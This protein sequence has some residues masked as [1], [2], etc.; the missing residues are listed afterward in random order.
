L[1]SAEQLENLEKIMKLN[2]LRCLIVGMVLLLSACNGDPEL[3]WK[4]IN[5]GALVVDVR[6]PD[7]YKAGH[8]AG[9]LLLPDYEIE[10]H[11]DKLGEKS[12][13]IVLYSNRG[14]RAQLAQEILQ[15]LGYTDVTNGGAY[16]VL[17]GIKN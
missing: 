9:A 6:T 1:C 4:K 14:K 5:A 15:G 8:L 3:A 13:A 16:E 11:Q 7:E 2:V 10:K 17:L 12:T